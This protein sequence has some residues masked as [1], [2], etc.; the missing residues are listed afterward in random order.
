MPTVADRV[1]FCET[2]IANKE[3]HAFSLKGRD[4]IREHLFAAADGFKLWRAKDTDPCADCLE[5]IGEIVGHPGDNPTRTA[6][7][8]ST[9]CPGLVAE[10][11]IVSVLN[12]QRQDGKTFGSMG[13]ALS[14]LF[15]GRNKSIGLLAASEDQAE[16]LFQENYAEAIARSPAL[17][18]RCE[19]TRMGLHVPKQR[20]RFEA[21]STAHRSVT[22]RS[23]TR[24]LIDEAR[25]IDARTVMAL[26]PAV[27]A[28]HGIECPRGHV[29]LD[30]TQAVGAP[31]TCSA[32]GERLVPW[33]GRITITSS[34]GVMDDSERDWL[35]ELIE[36]LQQE[37]HP[38]YHV[39]ASEKTLNPSKSTVIMGAVEDVFGRLETTRDY[40]AAEVGNQ[41]T[42][43][44]EAVVTKREID[45]CTD[46]KLT[47]LIECHDPSVAFLDTSDTV[48]LTSLV[49]LSWDRAKSEKPWEHAYTSLVE[50]WDPAKLPRRRVDEE[51]VLPYLVS[52]LPLYPHLV[53][54]GVD[55]RGRE[56]A[57]LLMARAR[58]TNQPWARLMRAWDKSDEESA[59]GWNQ[60]I[61]RI[62]S[63]TLR[64]QDSPQMR[65]EF[66]GIKLS[67]TRAGGTPRVIDRNRRKSH[68][69]VTESLAMCC[70]F[71]AQEVLKESRSSIARR[72]QRART[73]SDV[74]KQTMSP[75]F[76]R[77]GPNSF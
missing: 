9:G 28:M 1:R 29:Q 73:V 76:G 48:E 19:V 72:T 66:A 71:A 39:F 18:K 33:Y 74:A 30:A 42:R 51:E 69:D 61:A 24:L 54:F 6:E 40:V 34:S 53:T 31:E 64:M 8:R 15:L 14:D 26:I 25:D 27:F 3:G 68:K 7:H 77:L 22:G 35:A 70:Y 47:N 17:S 75:V 45:L 49:V 11:I 63:Q 55:T 10:P 23:R 52:R 13:L 41:W 67:E 12:L 62:K 43:K 4:Y 2:H 36:S 60:L 20:C 21:M 50:V 59:I 37:P 57:R 5:H 44:G 65:K 56:W 58:Q 38:N 46:S 32:C 16:R